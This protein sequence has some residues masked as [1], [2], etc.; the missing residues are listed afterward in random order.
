MRG[1]VRTLGR[2]LAWL[3]WHLRLTWARM[4]G[5][6]RVIAALVLL[7]LLSA[8]TSSVS[9]SVSALAQGLAVLLLAAV[10]FWMILSSPLRARRRRW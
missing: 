6:A 5:R 10:G 1:L 3:F 9:G 2:L 4:S 7:V 8:Q